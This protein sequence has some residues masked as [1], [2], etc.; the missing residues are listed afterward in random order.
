MLPFVSYSF[1][2]TLEAFSMSLM[3]PHKGSCR[4][5]SVLQ[6]RSEAWKAC[7]GTGSSGLRPVNHP[8]SY[9]LF[10]FSA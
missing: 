4:P 10:S 3:Q 9:G 5:R 2:A 7:L 8:E 6:V 1:P